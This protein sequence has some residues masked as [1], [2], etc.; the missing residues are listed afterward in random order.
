VEERM[1]RTALAE[2]VRQLVALNQQVSQDA[3]NLALALKGSS[4]TQGNWGEMVLERALEESGLRKDCDYFM[5]PT[6]TREDGSRVQPDAVIHLPENRVLIADSKVSLDAHDEYTRADT[7]AARQAALQAHLA[8]VRN[9]ING[10]STAN[11]QSIEALKSLDAVIM[12]VPIEPAFILAV[13][14]D[15]R[16][17]QD[18]WRK[19]VLMVS[20]SSL[21]FVVRIVANLW[22]QELQKRNVQEVVKRGAEL[23]DKLVGFVE[24]LKTLGQRLAQARDSY[25]SAYAKLHTGKGN[26]IRQAEMLK[27][28][29]VKPSKVLPVELVDAALDVPSLAA[30]PEDESESVKTVEVY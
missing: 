19:N 5:R 8:S 28:L 13:A 15:S 2:Q 20:P 1:D 4:K 22:R 11:Y 9:H 7:E 26:V 3:N 25:D 12:F 29:G 6:Y 16:L 14:N 18:A 21:L 23:Y 24:D 30:V 10:L 27:G 17:W